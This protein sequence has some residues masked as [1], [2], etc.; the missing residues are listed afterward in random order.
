MDSSGKRTPQKSK[1][2]CAMVHSCDSVE[3]TNSHGVLK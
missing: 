2:G 1:A 3:D